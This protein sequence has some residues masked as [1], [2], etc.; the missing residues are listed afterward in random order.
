[1]SENPYQSPSSISPAQFP[2]STPYGP[3]VRRLG[4]FIL[5]VVIIDIVLCGLRLL[6]VLASVVGSRQI[7]AHHPVAPSVPFELGTG[8]GIVLDIAYDLKRWTKAAASHA[9]TTLHIVLPET[10][11]W[12]V[13]P[14]VL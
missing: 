6:L 7:G 10:F 5:T 8:A 12:D 4:G 3:V 1:M 14:T 13:N 11:Q 2:A 9:Q